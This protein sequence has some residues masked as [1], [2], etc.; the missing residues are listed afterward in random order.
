[1]QNTDP[2]ETWRGSCTGVFWCS[3]EKLPAG[4]VVYQ[5]STLR[6]LDA[7][8]QM[9]ILYSKMARKCK[10]IHI[11]GENAVYAPPPDETEVFNVKNLLYNFTIFFFFCS[12]F[13]HMRFLT[14]H[15]SIQRMA[16]SFRGCD[17]WPHCALPVPPWGPFSPVFTTNSGEVW[18][19]RRRGQKAWGLKE[20]Y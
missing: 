9:A 6:D 12:L 11:F 13:I 15:M 16:V 7:I 14:L 18:Y 8:K 5:C 17:F 10:P 20:V 1:M 4:V 3:P 19:K 2:G